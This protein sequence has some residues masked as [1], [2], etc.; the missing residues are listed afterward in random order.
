MIKKNNK[1]DL[2]KKTLN[3]IKNKPQVK[4]TTLFSLENMQKNTLNIY[5]RV[6]S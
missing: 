6:M 3:F 5:L 2:T 4:K 1:K